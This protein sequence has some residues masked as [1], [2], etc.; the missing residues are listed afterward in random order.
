MFKNSREA[1]RAIQ[2]TSRLPAVHGAPIHIGDPAVIGI[3]DLCKA[4]FGPKNVAP[5][6]PDEIALYWACGGTP[7]PIIRKVK[8]PLAIFQGDL[9][10]LVTDS[11][12]A[13]LATL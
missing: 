3:K 4:D 9:E 1:V 11:L 2:I 6:Q 7:E 10:L 5:P 12:L 8:P 13:D